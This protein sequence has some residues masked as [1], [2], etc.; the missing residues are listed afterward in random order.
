MP[1]DCTA[2][3]ADFA[4]LA[5]RA[6]YAWRCED[7]TAVGFCESHW[8]WD[9]VNPSGSYGGLQIQAY[10]H[11][12]KLYAVTGSRDINLLLV[13]WVNLAVADIIYRDSGWAPWSCQP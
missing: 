1:S 3:C 7:V 6:E 9:A 5:C 10:W 11:M 2:A 13:P 12:D 4:A 8:Q